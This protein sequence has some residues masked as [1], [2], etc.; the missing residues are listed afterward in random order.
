MH[1]SKTKSLTTKLSLILL[2]LVL[3]SCRNYG[4]QGELVSKDNKTVVVP[5]FDEL[6]FEYHYSAKVVAYDKTLNGILVVKKMSENQKR[7][8]L[9]SDFGNTLFDFEFSNGKAKVIY[10][11]DN[12]NKKLLLNKLLLYFDFLTKS[13]YLSFAEY[14]VDGE[15]VFLSKLRGKRVK[16]CVPKFS[17]M[18]LAMMSRSRIKAEI[19]FFAQDKFADSISFESKE[20]PVHMF[21]KK[22]E[23]NINADQ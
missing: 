7:V 2:T 19:V 15:S 23:K 9:L 5:Y 13:D 18:Y 10:V 12:L 17:T 3:F 1:L 6:G 4:A 22:R 20:L 11:M 21:F 16:I 14:R 8:V